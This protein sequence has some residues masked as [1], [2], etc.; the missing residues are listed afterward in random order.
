VK[1][2]R[3]LVYEISV[4]YDQFVNGPREEQE[5]E[6]AS[7]IFIFDSIIRNHLRKSIKV[8]LFCSASEAVKTSL[9]PALGIF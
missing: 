3:S 8:W 5:K 9:V 2:N 4:G 6:L 7:A 1:P